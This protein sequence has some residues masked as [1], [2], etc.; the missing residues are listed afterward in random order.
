MQGWKEQGGRCA[1]Q[2]HLPAAGSLEELHADPTLLPLAEPPRE[3]V[4]FPCGA[5]AE[6]RFQH[7]FS[8]VMSVCAKLQDPPAHITDAH[9]MLRQPTVSLKWGD[10]GPIPLDS[11]WGRRGREGCGEPKGSQGLEK[12]EPI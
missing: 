1:P 9:L 10:A 4:T 7:L 12:A 6:L 11:H 2:R 8:N 3:T 5:R